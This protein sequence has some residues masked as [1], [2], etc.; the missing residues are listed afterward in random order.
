MNELD[1]MLS[2]LRG[3]AL[4]EGLGS[5]DAAVLSGLAAGRERMAGR[6]GLVLA[7]CIAGFVGLW[8]GLALPT[9]ATAQGTSPSEPLLAIP[10]AAPSHLLAL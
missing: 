10:A 4:P 8:G 1:E 7:G 9:S 2:M 6:R 3:E 5:L